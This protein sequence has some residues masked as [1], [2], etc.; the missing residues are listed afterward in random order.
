MS[1]TTRRASHVDTLRARTLSRET[2]S[3][4]DP[5]QTGYNAEKCHGVLLLPWY[6]LRDQCLG[7]RSTKECTTHFV[8]VYQGRRT[9]EYDA[10]GELNDAAAMWYQT[11][12]VVT[13]S[14]R[15]P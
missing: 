1:A 13:Q 6:V 8:P 11:G 3:A 14:P 5:V 4:D 10:Q 2:S 9:S 12:I 7:R 15:D